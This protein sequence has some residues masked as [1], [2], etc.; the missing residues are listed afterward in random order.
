MPLRIWRMI[1]RQSFLFEYFEISVNNLRWN[2]I[3]NN[4]VM[5]QLTDA[6]TALRYAKSFTI[7]MLKKQMAK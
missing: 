7:C 3:P 6:P 2:Y 5:L 4:R 1:F